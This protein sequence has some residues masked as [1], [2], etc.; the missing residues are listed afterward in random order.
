MLLLE[1]LLEEFLFDFPL[2]SLES[3]PPVSSS[4]SDSMSL[5]SLLVSA[6]LSLTLR[7]CSA[8]ETWGAGSPWWC[9]CSV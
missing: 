1:L 5:T 3:T 7:L 2:S 9:S 8:K 6:E 4:Q